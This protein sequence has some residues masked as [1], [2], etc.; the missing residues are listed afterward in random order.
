MGH[1]E[2]LEE[3]AQRRER[4]GAMGSKKR[5]AERAAA[6]VLNARERIDALLDP[7]SFS[8]VGLHAISANPQHREKSPA[9]GV[10]TG[11]GEIDGRTV[12]LLAHDF[13]T[14]G[15]STA[16]TY[17][18]KTRYIEQASREL[19]LPFVQLG[20]AGG[21]RLPD[22]L[23]GAGFGVMSMGAKSAWG[24]TRET[25]WISAVLGQCFGGPTWDTVRSDYVV[26]RKGAQLGVS[27]EQV[28]SVAVSEASDDEYCGWKMHTAE[29]GFV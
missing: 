21:A 15:A 17:S 11:F 7:G 6:G 16:T 10:V 19:G 29:T 8:E 3:L 2:R 13:T 26:M 9:D 27:S 4:A 24:R 12:A 22:S 20:E 5:L 23:D 1:E 25:P 18:R 28:T 14:L